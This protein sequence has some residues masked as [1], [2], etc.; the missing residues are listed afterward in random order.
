MPVDPRTL[1]LL[2]HPNDMLRQ[3]ADSVD[4]SDS[5]VHAVARRLMELMV[6]HEGAGLAAPQVGLPWRIF[7]TRDPEN[8]DNAI[9]WIN[10]ALEIVT[11]ELI[12][13]EEGCLSLPHVL[14]NVC[15][16][17]GIKIT[18][19]N[20]DGEPSQMT[21]EDHLARVWQHEYDHLEGILIIDK[22]SA[23][24]RLVNRRAIRTLELSV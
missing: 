12:T 8:S 3:K 2:L 24:D 7:V 6:Q 10:P 5:E 11:P 15:R 19:W 1:T 4:P 16:P 17:V 22:M 18:G 23:M 21:S 14:G 13:E 9:A 20:V